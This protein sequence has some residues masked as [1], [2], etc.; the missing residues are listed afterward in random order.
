MGA[1]CRVFLYH[2]VDWLAVSRS[3]AHAS[4]IVILVC[5]WITLGGQ[6]A[7]F[8]RPF[9]LV[10]LGPS[11]GQAFVAAPTRISYQASIDIRRGY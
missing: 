4:G 2:R 3:T 1:A 7:R 5:R 8:L 9:V 11:P 6:A 10:E